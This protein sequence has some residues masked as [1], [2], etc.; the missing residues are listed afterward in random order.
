MKKLLQKVF[1]L[2]TKAGSRPKKGKNK[3]KGQSLVELTLTLPII[4]MLFSGMVEFGFMLN[5]YLSLLDATRYSARYYSTQTP[6]KDDGSDDMSFYSYA[7]A[8]V[9]GQLEPDP[10]NP[11]GDTTRKITLNPA[12]DDVIISAYGVD[13]SGNITDYPDSGPFHQYGNQHNPA[14]TEATIR[15]QLVAGGPCEGIL[16]VEVDY[17]YHQVLGL[18]WMA[19]LGNPILPAYTIMPLQAVEPVC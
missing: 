14:V 4:L 16:V 18:P 9:M 7:S 12:T 15:S 8:A 1:T 19:W 3:S 5:D 13:A 2:S 10:H 6:L 11:N 17:Q